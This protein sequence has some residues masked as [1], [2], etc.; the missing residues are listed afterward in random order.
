M[1]EIDNIPRLTIGQQLFLQRL[2][3]SKIV[4]N[5]QAK[6]LYDS[7]FD[8]GEDKNNNNNKSLDRCIATI[9]KSLTKGF[10]FEIK[11]VSFPTARKL[12]HCVV[13]KKPDKIS[14]KNACSGITLLTPHT[15]AYLKLILGKMLDRMNNNNTESGDDDD[16][17]EQEGEKE[18]DWIEIDLINLRNELPEQHKKKINLEEAELAL[19]CFKC[20]KL[21][22]VNP[23]SGGRSGGRSGKRLK[24]GPRVYM[25]LPEFMTNF[26]GEDD[27][28]QLV[29][30]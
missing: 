12:Y 11:T 22:V 9:N 23:S 16:D 25:E 24:I 5:T 19:Q 28:P 17:D 1:Q 3:A 18:Q 8:D 7:I 29:V 15:L 13:N 6:S 2:I 21:L 10:A 4:S 14:E 20:E 27:M 30:Y 26:I